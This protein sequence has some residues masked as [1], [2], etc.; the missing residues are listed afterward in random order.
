MILPYELHEP[1]Q[2]IPTTDLYFRIPLRHIAQRG[3]ARL[4]PVRS[5]APNVYAVGRTGVI[6][7]YAGLAEL[8]RLRQSGVRQIVYIADDD[9]EAGANDPGLPEHYRARLAVFVEA[10]WPALRDAADIVLVSSPILAAIYGR[11]S[12][13]I[14]PVWHRPPAS[15]DHFLDPRRI[16]I[17][18]L[19]TGSHRSDLAP[20]APLLAEILDA[21]PDAR[22]TLFS[23]S[24]VPDELSRHPQ[25]RS[26]RPRKW[27]IYKRLLPRMRFHLAIYPLRKSPF[28]AARSANKLFEHA[29]AGAATLMSPNPALRE[30]ACAN[31][32]IFVEGD[33]DEWRSRIEAD[34][35]N[36]AACRQRADAIRE[37]ILRS[38]PLGE[39]ARHWLDILGGET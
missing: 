34:L 5:L 3:M 7:R 20:I 16:E 15:S 18:H 13:I 38:D 23:G 33:P 26:W 17:A 21:R 6:S 37:H 25:V 30:I 2:R 29:V 35:S 28:N 22:L 10:A 36:L 9:F 11:K 39:A 24:E 31:A 1:F 4:P 27:W 32:D 19:G 8:D 12:R 14:Q